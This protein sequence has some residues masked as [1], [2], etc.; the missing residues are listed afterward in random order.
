MAD[1]LLDTN[2]SAD[3]RRY[4]DVMISN[5]NS[6]LELINGILDL[7]RIESGRL[8]I[9]KSEFDLTE[10]VDNALSTFGVGAHT[11]GLELI[12][13]IA[14]GVP[15]RLIGDALRL[16]QVLINLVGNAIKFTERGEIMLEVS[17]NPASEEPG[18]LRFAVSDTGI[19]IP[20]NK[21]ESIFASFTQADSSTTR[22]YGGTGLGL[23][24]V[25]RLVGLMGGEIW[26]ESEVNEGSRFFFTARFGI[27]TRV[28]SSRPHA[29]TS[30]AGLPILV[31]D[32][33]HINRLI[34]R[35]MLSS[36]AADVTEA[37]S[38]AEAIEALRRANEERQPFRIILLDMRMPQMNGLE[39]AHTIRNEKL[40]TEPL[41]LMLSS[42][43]FKP[44]S[45]VLRDYGLD[46]Y[47]VKPITRRRLFDAINRVLNEARRGGVKPRSARVAN[48]VPAAP[49]VQSGISRI[50]VADDSPDNRLLIAAYLRNEPYQVDF[51]EDGKD[52]FEKFI[53]NDYDMVFMDAQMPEMDGFTATRTIRQWEKD[54]SRSRKPIIALS[55]SA[56]EEDVKRALD[57]GCDLHVS[58]PVK[59]RVML[60]TIRNVARLRASAVSSATAPVITDDAQPSVTAGLATKGAN[61]NVS[62]AVLARAALSP[63]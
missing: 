1:L 45:S 37:A 57:A 20:S 55:A 38:G 7:A 10:L 4:L 27:A 54:R 44:G 56:L 24:I 6:L 43:D 2:P 15:D 40:L 25:K 16:R 41:I 32:D 52:A 63:R 33:N 9:E 49:S 36:C 42:E 31:V 58:K 23:A 46:D 18:H 53:A 13:R 34:V 14:P 51:A 11:K 21:L 12:A 61:G 17:Q 8:Q 28:I 59:K 50:L 39:V 47:L 30:L 5:G 3:Q 26:V 62:T 19:G 29:E 60:D 35:E 48:E 22:Q